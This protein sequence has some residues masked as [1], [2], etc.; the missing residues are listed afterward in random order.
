MKLNWRQ[1]DWDLYTLYM[2]QPT[3]QASYYQE[4]SVGIGLDLFIESQNTPDR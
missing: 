1:K 2:Q 3:E 4:I